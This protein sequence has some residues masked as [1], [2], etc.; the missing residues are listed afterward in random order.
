MSR[1]KRGKGK[2]RSPANPG[3]KD[4]EPDSQEV[5]LFQTIKLLSEQVDKPDPNVYDPEDYYLFPVIST[6][7]LKHLDAHTQGLEQYPE[8]IV[9]EDLLDLE[10]HNNRQK[11]FAW[12]SKRKHYNKILRAK[13]KYKKD[14]VICPEAA[15]QMIKGSFQAIDVW[16]RFYVEKH[17]FQQ[18]WIDYETVGYQC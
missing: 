3:R 8:G 7:F 11:V 16:R 9:N 13:A 12:G 18:A 2:Q 6:A 15:W 14:Y 1:L 17:S 10:K 4:F 5:E